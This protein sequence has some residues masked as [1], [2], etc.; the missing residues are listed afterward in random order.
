MSGL[1]GYQRT[2]RQYCRG[3]LNGSIPV[4]RLVGLAVR[5]HLADLLL[6][7]SRGF[8]FDGKKSAFAIAFFESVLCHSTGEW[9][10]DP[11]RLEPWQKFVVWVVFG[12]RRLDGTRRFRRVFEEIGRKNGKT[13]KLAGLG[14]LLMQFDDPIEARAEIY[15]AAT[16]EDQAKI[17]AKEA[18][19]MVKAAPALKGRLK[20]FE[21]SARIV[22][23]ADDSTF[24]AVGSNSDTKDGLNPHAVL[25]DEL[26]AWREHHRGLYQKL[27][28]GGAA[29]RQPLEWVITTAGDDRSAL[30]KEKRDAAVRVLESM[31]TGSIVDDEIFAF[32]AC[33]DAED[34]PLGEKC[35]DAA[36]REWIHSDGFSR[37][38]AKANP[39]LGVSVKVDYLRSQA[40]VARND[41]AERNKFLRY[42]AN[43]SVSSS[44]RAIRPDIWAACKGELSQDEWPG[45]LPHGGFDLGRSDDFCAAAI[46]FPVP[47]GLFETVKGEDDEPCDVELIRYEAVSR[48][49]TCEKRSERLESPQFR[50]WIASGALQV[51]PGDQV[52]FTKVTADLA[53]WTR[54][55]NVQSWAYDDT[56]AKMVAQ[57]LQEEHGIAIFPF[58][59]TPRN[60]NEPTRSLLKLIRDPRRFRH[61]GDEMLAWQAGNLSIRKNARDEWMPDKIESEN[62]I[63]AMV[64]LLMAYHEVLFAEGSGT[65]S[66]YE[67]NELEVG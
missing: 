38:M 49:W 17:L 45:L 44:E 27:T 67:R 34:D 62:K 15:C 47:T 54:L 21:A 57:T 52:D 2:V 59:Q 60:Y 58:Y 30:W 56:F 37:V 10:G 40:V 43:R 6:A 12:W 20:T 13:A 35:D 23:P 50:R 66:F 22:C 29:R 19:R 39:N 36:F 55:Y 46:V 11:F 3:V 26:H 61:D 1:A 63:D 16:M 9:K 53:E 31:D 8:R 51:H 41:P 48:C 5:R 42:H 18:V 14:L 33:V 25:L 24:I 32:I 4:G 64:S 65:P 7:P 28:S